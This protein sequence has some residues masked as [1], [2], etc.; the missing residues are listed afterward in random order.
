[1]QPQLRILA[2]GIGGDP[3]VGDDDRINPTEAAIPMASFQSWNWPAGGKVLTAS[4]TLAFR[5]WA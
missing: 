2:G 5:A 1:M 4:R 3:D